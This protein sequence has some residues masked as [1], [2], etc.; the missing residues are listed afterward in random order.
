[1]KHYY[2]TG[3]NAQTLEPGQHVWLHNPKRKKGVSPKLSR[4]WEGPYTVTERLND[5]LYCI[6]QSP[7]AKNK[8][9]HRNRLWK[10]SS[11]QTP[12]SKQSSQGNQS[13]VPAVTTETS[14]LSQ[15][16]GRKHEK[17]RSPQQ[18]LQPR[19]SHRQ[20]RPPARYAA[21]FGTNEI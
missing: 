19:R 1:M 17:P 7:R 10:C 2:D 4:P 20:R 14:S 5:V 8:V 3:S 11:N 15:D 18:T 9:V 21:S 13:S 6:Q 16:S 12:K